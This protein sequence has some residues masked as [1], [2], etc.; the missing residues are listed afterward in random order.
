MLSGAAGH[1]YGANGIWQVNG[2]DRPYGPSP[3]GFSWGDTSWDTAAQLPGATQVAL[4]KRLLERYPWWRFAP[5]PEWYPVH[6]G[7]ENYFR[8]YAAGIPCEV[9]V[10][11]FPSETALLWL[12]GGLFLQQLEANLTY[13]AFWVNPV[14][15][16]E[17]P[18]GPV[19]ANSDGNWTPPHPPIF[20][21]WLLVL[22]RQLPAV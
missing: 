20:Q 18:C 4:G 19:E 8:P 15:G 11:Y 12:S 21:D 6:A 16:Q 7:P 10:F 1:T 3:H 5:H 2:R 17:Y 13:R 9:R 22:D 14:T